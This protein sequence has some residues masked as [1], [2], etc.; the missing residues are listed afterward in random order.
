[1]S[2]FTV[3]NDFS[4]GTTAESAKVN[5][6]FEDIE[7]QFN[8]NADSYV[9]VPSLVPIGSIVSWLKTFAS[10][11]SGNT[12]GIGAGTNELKDTGQNFNTTILVGMIVHNT[13][14]DTFANVTVVVSDTELTLDADIMDDSEDYTIYK[15]PK[16]ADGWIECDGSS[17]SDADSPYDGVAVPDLNSGSNR[18]LRGN[19]SSGGTGGAESDAHTHNVPR[20][21]IASIQN[22]G[23]SF[24]QVWDGANTT[25]N[26]QSATENRP[27]FYDVVWII[28]IK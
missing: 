27:P 25:T 8:G 10:A 1:M 9:P 21:G 5:K 4:P 3:T 28:R 18:F 11:D 20:V 17:V 7:D 6:N 19:T 26:S 24:T 22:A 14:D 12:D 13:T 23:G 15:T 16:L 2:D